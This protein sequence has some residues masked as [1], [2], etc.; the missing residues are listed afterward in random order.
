MFKVI[1]FTT[2]LCQLHFGYTQQVQKEVFLAVRDLVEG[3]LIAIAPAK[4]DRCKEGEL[5]VNLH[6]MDRNGRI[7]KTVKA[8]KNEVIKSTDKGKIAMIFPSYNDNPNGLEMRDAAKAL[9]KNKDIDVYMVETKKKCNRT[10]YRLGLPFV[11][12]NKIVAEEVVHK[13]CQNTEK[14]A[15]ITLGATWN[16]SESDSK[17]IWIA[18]GTSV[19]GLRAAMKLDF[20]T[21]IAMHALNPTL[22]LTGKGLDMIDGF[23]AKTAL[24][25]ADVLSDPE[26]PTAEK[27]LL[28]NGGRLQP[29]CYVQ[30]KDETDIKKL[31]EA[32]KC[33]DKMSWTTFANAVKTRAKGVKSNCWNKFRKGESKKEE[34]TEFYDDMFNDMDISKDFKRRTKK[35]TSQRYYTRTNTKGQFV[36]GN[37]AFL[38]HPNDFVYDHDNTCPLKRNGAGHGSSARNTFNATT[39]FSLLLAAKYM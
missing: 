5:V 12:K 1:L 34:K 29:G 31:G 7:V 33:S 15:K 38:G 4:V 26:L 16:I 19:M 9:I 22:S 32:L 21:K 3:F 37:W 39:V 14:V 28:V 30:S 6:K 11:K 18:K 36:P 10:N 27:E 23:T 2:L 25:T 24:H 35:A 17:I 8:H 20:K 13:A